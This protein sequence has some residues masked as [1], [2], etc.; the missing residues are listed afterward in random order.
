MSDKHVGYVGEVRG[1]LSNNPRCSV[2]GA[3][4]VAGNPWKCLSCGGTAPGM[5]D[6][7]VKGIPEDLRELYEF[8]TQD[9]F[10]KQGIGH[11]E[12]EIK[13]ILA[14]IERI[15]RSEQ[16]LA[17]Q[18]HAASQF[19]DAIVRMDAE[20]VKH[21]QALA[22]LEARNKKAE[23]LLLRWNKAAGWY[24]AGSEFVDDPERVFESIKSRMEMREKLGQRKAETAARAALK[25]AS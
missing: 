20:K 10:V 5:S 2:C 22:A 9:Y 16:A 21:E 7:Q 6:E 18:Y 11:A 15:A 1:D 8:L 14:I 24:C 3:V 19:A 17:D 4:M 13:P 25:G 12:L 23:A